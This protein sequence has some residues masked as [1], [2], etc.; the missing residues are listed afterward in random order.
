MKLP[1][2]YSAARKALAAANIEQAKDIRN[3]AIGMAV[4]AYQSKDAELVAFSTEIKRRATR[5]IGQLMEDDRKAGKLAKAGR[6]S[7]KLGPLRTQLNLDK[8]GVDKHLADQARKLA[9]LSEDKF[10]AETER[11]KKIAAAA[12]LNDKEIIK[13]A[14]AERHKK[15]KEARDKR[16]KELA[17]K[18]AALPRKKYAVIYADPEWKWE[19][20]SEK[21]LDATSADNHYPTSVVEEIKN[22]K[23]K[24]IAADDC[25]LFL[26]STVP[27]LPQALDVLEAWGF[28]Y[29]S[30]FCWNKDRAG[31]GYWNRNKHET[32]LIGTKGKIPAPLEG[33]QFE[34]VIDAPVGKHSA[35]PEKF[36]QMIEAYYPD[37]PKIE[38]NARGRAPKGWDIWGNEAQL[39]AAE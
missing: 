34:S 11:A 36:R 25:V 26:W 22:R 38:L 12:A 28:R 18:L 13:T 33:T 39:E 37:L 35:K 10:E 1:A 30:N 32:L 29:V 2:K 14:R 4:Y 15:K 9:A 31:T 6:P 17:I 23:I 24:S 27:M 7:K 5:R 8:Q 16:V 3:K 20:W 21:G 19:A